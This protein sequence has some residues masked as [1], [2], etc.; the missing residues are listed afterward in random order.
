MK[1]L[2]DIDFGM[3]EEKKI[4][5]KVVIDPI[6]EKT[7]KRELQIFRKAKIKES[8]L[9]SNNE[10][11]LILTQ[12]QLSSIKEDEKNFN[13]YGLSKKIVIPSKIKSYIVINEM[14]HKMYYELKQFVLQK[15]K[16][17]KQ[18][19]SNTKDSNFEVISE[20][21]LIIQTNNS[22]INNISNVSILSNFTQNK[23]NLT[24]INY[25]NP[26]LV[27][28]NHIIIID[29][30]KIIFQN[31]S[32]ISLY[33]MNLTSNLSNSLNSKNS[34][35][36]SLS[37]MKNLSSNI[38]FNITTNNTSFNN[39]RNDSYL[40]K[41]G[42]SNTSNILILN[43]N[44]SNITISSN[45]SNLHLNNT[46]TNII[47]N[48][49]NNHINLT[50]KK[51]SNN[52][53]DLQKNI[54]RNVRNITNN[55]NNTT[56][57][58]ISYNNSDLQNLTKNVRNI[59]NNQNNTTDNITSNNNSDLQKNLTKNVRNITNNQNNTT[60]NITSNNSD[61]PKNLTKN[62]R[63][64]TNNQNNP[65]GNNTSN[66]NTDLQKNLTRNNSHP[67]NNNNS[68]NN[69]SSLPMNL[70][71]NNSN[72]SN[73]EN[74]TKNNNSSKNISNLN[75]NLFRNNS[76]NSNLSKN[77]TNLNIKN[78]EVNKSNKTKIKNFKKNC[79]I[80]NSNKNISN[81]TMN[82]NNTLKDYAIDIDKLFEEY[83]MSN[84]TAINNLTLSNKLNKTQI[85]VLINYTLNYTEKV[86]KLRSQ[87]IK[88]VEK[89]E[90]NYVKIRICLSKHKNQSEIKNHSLI[91]TNSSISLFKNK[92]YNK[93]KLINI[94]SKNAIINKASLNKMKNLKLN[95][96]SLENT[97]SFK[98]QI[99]DSSLM[100]HTYTKIK[101]KKS[102]REPNSLKDLSSSFGV[103]MSTFQN[104]DNFDKM[105]NTVN[106]DTEFNN[107]KMAQLLK[108]IK[109]N[110]K[111]KRSFLKHQK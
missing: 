36:I 109:D 98:N 62:V 54:N 104:N 85:D 96:Y 93:S 30:S 58:N 7:I 79:S 101:E 57:N 31:I 83:S 63:N 97:N 46:T 84:L 33:N 11:K 87:V 56:G 76:I 108:E 26:A 45:K 64:I 59:T 95:N 66:N 86:N 40:P 92:K 82:L 106:E 10:K 48:S 74:K 53:S 71:K 94:P 3:K 50:V 22:N 16:I 99:S 15:S 24:L 9:L 75:L 12:N 41:N 25:T 61:L 111:Q 32:N 107:F 4:I 55:Q 1:K 81:T 28:G 72:F 49:S 38:S 70:T 73:Y 105:E 47:S 65:T 39:S 18:N 5:R 29:Q 17:M 89:K 21:N 91:I 20:K 27:K 13:Y 8:S 35:N 78:I 6:K 51:T 110:I 34:N 102:L 103:D 77:N 37:M 68:S 43:K 44:I 100:D 42:A 60:D 90:N 14:A 19:K 67:D 2:E 23:K 80:N 88:S 69:L 52:N